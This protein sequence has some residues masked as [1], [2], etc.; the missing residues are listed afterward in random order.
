M[1]KYLIP[2][3]F[4]LAAA[5][6]AFPAAAAITAD[7]S[8]SVDSSNPL[9]IHFTD[10]STG[11]VGNWFWMFGD[12]GGAVSNEQNPTHTYSSEGTYTVYLASTDANYDG[13]STKT[14]QLTITR[15][16]VTDDSGGQ[17]GGSSSGGSSSGGQSGGNSGGGISFPDISLGGISIPNPLDLIGE[18]IK[19]IRVM[20]IPGNY[21]L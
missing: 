7:F 12:G 1:K 19:L 11:G 3:T 10:K 17:S 6:F 9:T 4:L 2:L 18:Y 20:V 16:G 13:E 14:K 15:N 5:L 8:Y 21:Q